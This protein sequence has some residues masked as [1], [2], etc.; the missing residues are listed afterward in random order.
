MSAQWNRRFTLPIFFVLAAPLQVALAEDPTLVFDFGRT[1][2]CLDVT[3][4]EQALRYPG[5]KVVEL[6]L[7]VSVHLLAGNINSVEEIRIEVGD[8]DE[9]MRVHSF[10]PSTRLESK[11]SED[12]EWTKTVEKG[13][14]FGASLGGEAPVLLGDVVAHVTPTINGGTTRR[15]IVTESQRRIAPKHV[16]VASGNLW[17]GARGVL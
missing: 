14:S 6:N 17:P 9:G 4:E 16:V 12:I 1:A 5:K 7:R 2:E 15:E 8:C 10:E 11:V 3:S 13:K